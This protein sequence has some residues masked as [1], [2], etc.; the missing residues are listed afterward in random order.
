MKIGVLVSGRGSNLQALIDSIQE[1]KVNSK[2]AVVISNRKE[3]PALERA[4]K[5]A[6]PT[7]ILLSQP[8][9]NREN[10]NQKLAGVLQNYQVDLVVLAGFM[11]ILSPQMISSYPH[12]IINI[13]P[14]L[15]PAFPGLDAQKQALE[16]GVRTSGCT[17]HFVDEGCDTGPVILQKEVPVKPD[18]TVET[19]SARILVEE[20]KL[21]PKVVDLLARNKVKITGHKVEIEE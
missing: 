12:R 16:A 3:A 13:H 17:V 19:L 1:G 10:Y 14:S 20:H 18:D 7:R 15:L 8:G 21:L 11:R 6:I 9:E 4:K 5:A 2:I